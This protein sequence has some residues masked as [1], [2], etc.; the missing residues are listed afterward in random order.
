MS[1]FIA[2]VLAAACRRQQ[3]R[4]SG[5]TVDARQAARAELLGLMAELFEA[6]AE[7]EAS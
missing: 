7:Q 3:E 4:V 5:Q 6:V 1:A 2:T